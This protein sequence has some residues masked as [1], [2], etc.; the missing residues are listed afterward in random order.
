MMRIGILSDTHGYMD[1]K[2]LHYLKDC[3]EIWHAGDV[4]DFSIVSKLEEV[5]SVR[6]VYGNIDGQNVRVSL[7]EVQK[8]EIENIKVLMLH[9][10]GY[11]GT[12]NPKAR[13]LIRD[14][15]PKIVVCGH[16]HILK[17][18]NDKKNKHL[19]INPGAVG[20]SGFHKIR[21]MIRLSLDAG[22]IKDMEVI[23]MDR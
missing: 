9:I 5:T 6:A 22:N 14:F 18:V 7:P 13:E 17:V 10:A 21:T 2:T 4:G 15:S 11:P 8:F 1:E 20:K 3:D 12:Y 19:H 23:E 16:S